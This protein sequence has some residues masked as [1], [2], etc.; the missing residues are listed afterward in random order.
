M[1]G[2]AKHLPM[3]SLCGCI[4]FMTT[5]TYW[6]SEKH[7]QLQGWYFA[8]KKI[9]IMK[10]PGLS[11]S[12]KRAVGISGLKTKIARKVGIPT[13]RQGL[14]RKIGGAILNSILGKK[15]KRKRL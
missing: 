1:A 13:T 6:Q 9:V 14:E 2:T 15:N 8:Q 4:E 11:F 3:Q 12:L 5:Y 10:I 7:W